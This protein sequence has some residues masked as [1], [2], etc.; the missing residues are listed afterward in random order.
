MPNDKDV[1]YTIDVANHDGSISKAPQQLKEQL[2][3]VRIPLWVKVVEVYHLGP[4]IYFYNETALKLSQAYD[5]DVP[6]AREQ[7][8]WDEISAWPLIPF[9]LWPKTGSE[10]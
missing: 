10:D 6:R 8:T 5:I 4:V 2:Q 1:F 9:I 7:H 3:N